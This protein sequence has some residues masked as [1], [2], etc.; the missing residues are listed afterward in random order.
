M[1]TRLWR[2]AFGGRTMLPMRSP[3]RPLIA[4]VLIALALAG[5]GAG[6]RAADSAKILHLASPDIATLD[7]QQYSDDP[8]FQV[9]AAIFESLYEYD[10]LASPPKL[11]PLTA[12]GPV[13]IT[14]DGKVWTSVS[15]TASSSPMTRHSRANR[16]S[17]LPRTTSIRTSAGS[18]PT[19]AAAALR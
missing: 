4:S 6:V 2:A 8:S 1:I 17:W 11:T 18:I 10:Y 14:P 16:A 9:M 19:G 12:D 15:S 3:T 7:P 5:G 13:D